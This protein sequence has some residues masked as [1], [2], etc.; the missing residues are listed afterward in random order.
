MGCDLTPDVVGQQLCRRSW[1]G[2]VYRD[3][4]DEY[5]EGCVVIVW[6]SVDCRFEATELACVVR[7][8]VWFVVDKV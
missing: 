7:V 4:D 2:C 6:V 8:H 1:S 3:G 5:M